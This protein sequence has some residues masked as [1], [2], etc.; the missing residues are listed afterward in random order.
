MKKT[1]IA[2]L[3]AVAA[4]AIQQLFHVEIS[5]GIQNDVVNAIFT[6]VSVYGIFA[7]HKKGE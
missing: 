6:V 1:V 7:N 2:P 5:E 3:I 4:I